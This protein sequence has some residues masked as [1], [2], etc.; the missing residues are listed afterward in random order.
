MARLTKAA[1]HAVHTMR[2]QVL[3]ETNHRRR[4][5]HEGPVDEH[6]GEALRG[7]VVAQDLPRHRLLVRHRPTHAR[8]ADAAGEVRQA[9]KKTA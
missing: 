8:H 7:V 6:E 9:L 1:V 2:V 4:L 5:S 3:K